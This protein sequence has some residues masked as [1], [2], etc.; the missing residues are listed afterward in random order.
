MRKRRLDATGS[1]Y[2]LSSRRRKRYYIIGVGNVFRWFLVM[3]TI[4]LVGYLWWSPWLRIQTIECK[5]AGKS[6]CS[7]VVWAEAKQYLGHHTF[8]LKPEALEERLLSVNPRFTKVAVEPQLPQTLVVNINYSQAAAMLVTSG[9][10]QGLVVDETGK[11]VG[12]EKS[13]TSQL[14]IITVPVL[15]EVVIG[16]TIK[17]PTHLAAL[18][19]IQELNERLMTFEHLEVV[20]NGEIRLRLPG[21][22]IAIFSAGSDLSRQVTSLQLIL[23]KAT[24]DKYREIDLRFEH[25][26]LR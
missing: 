16:N 2:G 13:S 23:T 17:E 15:D 24:I 26:V 20:V 22:K 25:P 10:E 1:R 9:N 7:E 19:L 11:V 5:E 12:M 8:L 3:T 4:F 21:G 6:E 18:V 14:P